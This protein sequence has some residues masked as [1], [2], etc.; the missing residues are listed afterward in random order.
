LTVALFKSLGLYTQASYY[1]YSVPEDFYTFGFTP[2]LDRRSVSAGLTAWLPLI[3]PPR[4]RRT[5][6]PMQP[7]SIG[8]P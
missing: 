6:D 2:K 3:K 1:K 7:N 5:D 4:V 8:Q